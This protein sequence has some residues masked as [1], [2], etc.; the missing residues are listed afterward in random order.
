[1]SLLCHYHHDTS[2]YWRMTIFS[3]IVDM[4]LESICCVYNVQTSQFIKRTSFDGNNNS[5]ASNLVSTS[6]TLLKWKF[7]KSNLKKSL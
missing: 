2:H 7:L 1:M 4:A 3:K 5:F 6:L